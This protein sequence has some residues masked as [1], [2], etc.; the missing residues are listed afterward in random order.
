MTTQRQ[1]YR[2]GHRPKCLVIVDETAEWDRAV[3]YASRWAVRGGGGVV[4]LRVIETL[5][6]NQQ[7]LGVADVMRAEAIEIAETV[8]DRASGRANGIAAITPER[9]IREGDPVAQILDVIDKD[10]DI[11][12]L[13][14]AAG[15]GPEG[16][17]PI[18]TTMVRSLGSFPIPVTIVAASLTDQDIDAMS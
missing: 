8:L 1:S 17:G 9:V 15:D 12:L 11:A 18:I 6:R 3:Y 10:V 4:M 13:V 16:P 5:D 7:W 2:P 14:L